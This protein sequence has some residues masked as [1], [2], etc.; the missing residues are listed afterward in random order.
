M[1]SL[2]VLAV[3]VVVLAPAIATADSA[4]AVLPQVVGTCNMTI[5]QSVQLATTCRVRASRC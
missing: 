1:R 4:G 5:S 2:R 3:V